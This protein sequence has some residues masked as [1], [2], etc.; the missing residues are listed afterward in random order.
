MALVPDISLAPNSRKAMALLA[1][2]MTEAGSILGGAKLL[3]KPG[4]RLMMGTTSA[5]ILVLLGSLAI[6]S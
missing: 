6:C 4:L 5:H 2:P 1:T 3:V